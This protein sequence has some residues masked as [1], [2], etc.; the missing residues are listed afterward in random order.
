MAGERSVD[1]VL[2]RIVKGLAGHPDVALARVWLLRPGDICGTCS[3]RP[4][5]PDQFRCL[6]LVASAGTPGA[7]PGEDWSRVDGNF[8]RFPLGVFKVGRVGAS[9]S[10]LLLN[11]PSAD[12]WARPEWIRR[13]GIRSFAGQPLVFRGEMLGVLAVFRR[14]SMRE[15]EF[16][17]LRTFADHAAVAIANGRAFVEIEHLRHQLEAENAY[18][19]E[20]V[21]TAL[22]FGS[23]VGQSSALRQVTSR[24]ELVARTDATVLILGESGTGK[25]L[26]AR[27]IHE[28]SRRASRPLIKV[29]CSALP[30][31]MFESEFFGHVRG[32]FTGAL[33][34]RPGRFHLADRGTILLDEV[35]D[36]PLELQPKLLR[37]LQEGQYERVGED[38][39]RQVD[40]RVL[41]ATNRDLEAE[42]R[43]GR[44]RE[45]LYYRL[46]VFPVELPPLRERKD[47]IPMLAAHFVAIAARRLG[48][49]E[50]AVTIAECEE[51]TRYDWPGNIREL[52]NVIERAV[53]LSDGRRLRLDL[54]S[55][56]H[57]PSET[58]AT[59]TASD[60]V[61]PEREW[62]RR[63]RANVLAA[64]KRA[65]GR[66]HGEGGAA[67][68]LGIRPSTLQSRLKAL[69]I[70][71]RDGA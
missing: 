67:E 48:V 4:I 51:L 35:G 14:T 30:P 65:G 54:I 29:N 39:S 49:E 44:F 41:A 46:S 28:R 21:D 13:E 37:V 71:P 63:E 42:V 66:V 3:M 47:D 17:W 52:Q 53:I 12:A 19:R 16:R 58:L 24:L 6:H 59:P 20:E 57:G 36:L 9:G 18:L 15:D 33:R 64:L 70:S 50:P 22:A 11:D 55:L 43:A 68:L 31:G 45:D 69:G 40:V 25:E 60:E 23:I 38:T 27:E 61:V 8:R 2:A 56:D 1:A 5:C 10:A 32:A 7:S 26:V 34:D 62:R